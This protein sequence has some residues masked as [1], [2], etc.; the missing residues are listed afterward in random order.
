MEETI[1]VFM[2]DFLV[3][4]D[5][6]DQCLSHLAEVL[7]RCEDFNIVINWKKMSLYGER[8]YK[9]TSLTNPTCFNRRFIIDFS[10]TT[11]PL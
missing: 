4:G 6:F 7:K 5:S 2:D 1:E 8:R 10:K 3:V 11:H 9:E